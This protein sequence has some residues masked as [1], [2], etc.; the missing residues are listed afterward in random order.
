MPA[1]K[2][3]AW[4]QR[5]RSTPDTSG[6]QP[7]SVGASPLTWLILLSTHRKR[8]MSAILCKRIVTFK[9]ESVHCIMPIQRTWRIQGPHS[10]QRHPSLSTIPIRALFSSEVYWLRQSQLVSRS[11][12]S[13]SLGISGS[14]VAPRGQALSKRPPSWTSP[15]SSISRRRRIKILRRTSLRCPI[16]SF[17]LR[18]SLCS[19]SEP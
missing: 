14:M 10:L 9:A 6:V 18:S 13:S 19:A 2:S 4:K 16:P 3:W 8:A 12:I 7:T 11:V 17:K 5:S 15:V 1:T